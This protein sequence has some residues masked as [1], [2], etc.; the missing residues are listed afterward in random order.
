MLAAISIVVLVL[1]A[2]SVWRETPS[3][4]GIGPPAT[5]GVQAPGG[6][7][8]VRGTPGWEALPEADRQRASAPLAESARRWLREEREAVRAVAAQFE[9]TPVALGGIVAAEKTLLV[10]RVDAL[11][12]ELF[13]SVFGSLREADLE[14]WVAD[15]ERAFQLRG[16]FPGRDW[17]MRS[18]YLWTLGPAQVS[19]RLAIQYEPAVARR[20]GRSRRSASEVLEA[21]V[22]MPGNL[23]YAAALL[24]EAEATYRTRAGM[25]IADNPG[26]LATLYHLGSPAVRARRLSAD[27]AARRRR[28]EPVEPPQVNYYGAFVNRHADEIERL[29]TLP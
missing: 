1:L 7:I 27:N 2:R 15:Q 6:I 23:E 28:G 8:P 10:G 12:E 11:G 24:A 18:P 21:L 19:F 9:V 14:R 4:V 16:S 26:V 17:A 22:T 5:A 25:D 20:I 13:R 29:L 3:R